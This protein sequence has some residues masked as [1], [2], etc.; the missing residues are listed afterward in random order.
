[1]L[2]GGGEAEPE[3]EADDE[4]LAGGENAAQGVQTWRLDDGEVQVDGLGVPEQLRRAV[5]AWRRCGEGHGWCGRGAGDR[6]ADGGRR[7]APRHAGERLEQRRP[8][9]AVRDTDV[10]DMNLTRLGHRTLRR[11]GLRN[12]GVGQRVRDG[13]PWADLVEPDERGSEQARVDV[14]ERRRRA[15]ASWHLNGRRSRLAHGVREASREGAQPVRGQAVV[16]FAG[17]GGQ[18]TEHVQQVL[19]ARQVAR[20]DGGRA[21]VQ[22]LLRPPR[23]PV[24]TCRGA[25][26][27]PLLA[28]LRPDAARFPLF[29]LT[30]A[31]SADAN[32]GS[33]AAAVSRRLAFLGLPKLLQRGHR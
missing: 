23:L 19:R 25:L 32:M 21:R 12:R 22:Q 5:V 18:L 2:L 27:T 33:L 24:Q 9:D 13:E 28:R 7:G 8:L 30:A 16:G 11:R 6:E 10:H 20:F 31:S 26:A 15:L 29:L 17:E 4:G 3:L 14:G 1:L